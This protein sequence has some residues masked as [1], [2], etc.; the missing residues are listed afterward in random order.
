[1]YQLKEELKEHFKGCLIPQ[2]DLKKWASM[3]NL[4]LKPIE[5][6]C[7][8]RQLHPQTP[9][10]SKELRGIIYEQCQCDE[11][12]KNQ[13]PFLYGAADPEERKRDRDFAQSLYEHI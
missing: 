2:I 4:K 3:H 9:F 7:C 1:M 10:A 6:P 13:A 5:C 11:Y 8:D 12:P